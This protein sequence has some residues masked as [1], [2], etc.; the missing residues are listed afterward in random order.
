VWEQNATL[1]NDSNM[2]LIN[3]IP[4]SLSLDVDPY[5]LETAVN[6][7]T[8]NALKYG[9]DRKAGDPYFKLTAHTEK[10]TCLVLEATD[11]GTGIPDG[12]EDKLFNMFHRACE[13]SSGPGLGLYI[14]NNAIKKMNGTIQYMGNTNSHTTFQIKVPL[15]QQQEQELYT[16]LPN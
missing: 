1:A 10:D 13:H 3:E 7:L 2:K 6:E 14:A 9:G 12:E 5:L 16:V 8:K 11:N 15:Q 4:E